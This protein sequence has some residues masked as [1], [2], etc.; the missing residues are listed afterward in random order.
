MPSVDSKR[1]VYQGKCL[2]HDENKRGKVTQSSSL[3]PR[4]KTQ[5]DVKISVRGNLPEAVVPLERE[6]EDRAE[7]TEMESVRLR[8][9]VIGI[10]P[11]VNITKH[12][13]DAN[14]AKSACSGQ[15][16]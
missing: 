12:N 4:L 10:L 7:I 8:H 9:V 5:N 16:R 11:Y 14:S 3:A 15:R 2:R 6:P 1:T 13:R